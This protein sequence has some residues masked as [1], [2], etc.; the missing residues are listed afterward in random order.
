MKRYKKRIFRELSYLDDEYILSAKSNEICIYFNKL[1]IEMTFNNRYPFHPPKLY[2]IRDENLI[3]ENTIKDDVEKSK[4]LLFYLEKFNINSGNSFTKS[5]CNCL[6]NNLYRLGINN[7]N[8]MF[9]YYKIP[10]DVLCTNVR[11]LFPKHCICGNS[12][13]YDENCGCCY[14]LKHILDNINKCKYDMFL[15]FNVYWVNN[16]LKRMNKNLEFSNS[17][18]PDLIPY[19]VDCRKI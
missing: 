16:Y 10:L 9:S 11:K 15:I 17:N 18:G 1:K 3:D 14:S 5:K 13:L 8:E 6:S 4:N 7:Y 12:I 19:L 2:L